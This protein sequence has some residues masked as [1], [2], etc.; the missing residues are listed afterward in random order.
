MKPLAWDRFRRGLLITPSWVGDTMMALPA[1]HALEAALPDCQ[2]ALLARPAPASGLRAARLRSPVM[3]W[4]AAR[5]LPELLSEFRHLRRDALKLGGLDF[6]LLFPNSFHAAFEA[7]ALG[8]RARIGYRRDGRGFLLTHALSPPAPG[9][10]PG[11]E[12]FYYLELLRR[13]GLIAELPATVHAQ[14]WAEP[15]RVELWRGRLA[16]EGQL[17]AIHAGAAYGEAKRW[18]PSYFAALLARLPDNSRVALVG[19]LAERPLA[20]WMQAQAGSRLRL[21]NLAGETEID[22]LLAVFSLADAVLAN[23]SGPM[24]LAAAL[25]RPLVALFGPTNEL[26]TYPLGP[27]H[28]QGLRLLHAEGISCRPCKLRTCPIDHRCM[29]RLDVESVRRALEERLHAAG[30]KL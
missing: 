9:S 21:W 14:L 17:V 22:D 16:G 18:P 6:V 13:A 29:R 27:E 19:S 2:L 8:G 15:E 4:P 5:R 30:S 7:A 20:N 24:H 28:W 10:L 25:G 12:S 23:D 3:S 26:E 11:H 1:I